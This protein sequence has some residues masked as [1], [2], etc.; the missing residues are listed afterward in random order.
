MRR[1]HK[2]FSD[3]NHKHIKLTLRHPRNCAIPELILVA[4]NRI[5]LIL[6][7]NLVVVHILRQIVTPEIMAKMQKHSGNL[8]ALSGSQAQGHCS[9]RT[10]HC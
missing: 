3:I 1:I 6:A 9:R 4:Q 7:E 2:T 10:S 8:L 5:R